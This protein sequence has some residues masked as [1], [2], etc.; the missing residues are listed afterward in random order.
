MDAP[1]PRSPWTAA[2]FALTLAVAALTTV[3]LLRIP[4]QLTDSFTEFMVVHNGSLWQIVSHEFQGGPYMRP[5]RRGLI[6]V[7]YD[8]S[9]GQYQAAFRGFQAAQLV[10][11][12]VLVVRAL[13]VRTRNDAAVVP[14]TLALVLGGHTFAGAIL[15]GLPINHFLTILICCA[16]ALNLVRAR[17]SLLVDLSAVAVMIFA[18]LTIES[19]LVVAAIF[20][21]AYAVGYRGVSRGALAA[22]VLSVVAYCVGRF[23]YLGGTTPGLGER[24]AGFGFRVLS[25][26]EL[27]GRFGSNPL[28]FYLYNVVCAFSSVL[29]AEPR[30]G[31]WAFTDGVMHG[32]PEL[33]R[34]LSVVSSTAVTGVILVVA[35]RRIGRWRLGVFETETDR[36]LVMC[37]AVLCANA[38]FAFAYE[39]DA[40]LGP[41]GLFYALA[42][43]TVLRDVVA[44]AASVRLPRAV[45]T[46]LM[47]VVACGWTLRLMGVHYS[48]QSRELTVRNE[49]AYY[50]D[51][52]R[53]QHFEVPFTAQEMA[54]VQSLRR[55]AIR[56][57][58][59]VRQFTSRWP[60][61]LFDVSQ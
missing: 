27:V 31:V 36:M 47:L 44:G 58:G 11:L 51:W 53:K 42:A 23:M 49:W 26:D 15:E 37:L 4:V 17:P 35:S 21:A 13:P 40:I 6:K 2:A 24:S 30:G 25:A 50:D 34:L 57:S 56:G 9:G 60:D 52:E 32:R 20:V 38:V 5:F 1:A 7:V 14:M 33:W 28:P 22:V 12:L 19:G 43:T 8:L 10:A 16:L 59:G 46:T 48:L 54:I 61:R 29:F 41:A 39:K 55:Q 3:F 18:M 45:M